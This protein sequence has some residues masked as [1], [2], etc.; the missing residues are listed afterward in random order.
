MTKKNS[1]KKMSGFK[2]HLNL[3]DYTFMFIAAYIKHGKQN[4]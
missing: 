1:P 4:K 3:N 2:Y